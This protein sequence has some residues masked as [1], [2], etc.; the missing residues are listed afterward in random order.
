[1]TDF[2]AELKALIAKGDDLPTLPDTILELRS[3]LESD[4]SGDNII[5]DIISRDPVITGK[6]LRVANSVA[7]SRGVE[8]TSVL[9]AIQR[10]GLREVRAICVVLAVVDAFADTNGSLDLRQFWDHSAAVGRVAQLLSRK[11]QLNTAVGTDDIYVSGLLHDVGILLLSQFFP[12]RFKEMQA[13]RAESCV[14]LWEAEK[15][16]IGVC[17]GQ[18]GGILTARWSLPESINTCI[19][20]HHDPEVVPE[21]YADSCRVLRTSEALCTSLGCGVDAE[22]DA[23]DDTFTALSALGMSDDQIDSTLSDIEEVGLSV[24]G[25]FV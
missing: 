14:P 1:M 18:V 2:L 7:Y 11:L 25:I 17:H 9:N 8:V 23:D 6:L 20:G 13:V 22:G 10:V 5:A 16:V 19:S 21:E 12:D 4:S 3:A 15:Q 24:R